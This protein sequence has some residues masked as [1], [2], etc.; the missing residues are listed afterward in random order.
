M[1]SLAIIV[2]LAIATVALG[3]QQSNSA[4]VIHMICDSGC[5]GAGGG[6]LADLQ[7]RSAANAW[8]DVGF[9]A[10]NL[11]LPAILQT[12]GNVIGSIS[13]SGF[14]VNNFPATQ[15][16]SS[17]QLPAALDG[18]GFLKTHEQGTAAT[19]TADGSDVTQ[20]SKADARSTS[21]DATPI[22]LMQVLKEISFMEQT[23]AARSVTQGTSPWVDSITLW[24][25]GTLGAMAAFGT[26]P[27]AVL[28]PGVN[29]FVT[30]FPTAFQV[31][32]FPATQAVTQSTSPWVISCSTVNCPQ[33]TLTKGTQ[34]STG[35]STQ[36]LKDSGRSAR[37][38]TLDSF[39][40]A[41]TT[42]T[43]MTMSY[44]TDNATLTTGTSYT[45]TAA[46][47][48]RIQSIT[49]NIHTIAGNTTAVATIVRLRVNNGG[50]AVVTS[51]VQAILAIQGVAAASQAGIPVQV[52]FPDGWEFVAGAGIGVTVGCGGFV[53]TTAAPKVDI[54]LV[55]FEY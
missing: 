12:G 7:V 42:E 48:L 1:R 9:F 20:G 31:S 47:R 44:S 4:N 11:F 26:S 34:G 29:A 50:A 16:I 15:A 24:A 45:V 30:N 23:P 36:D 18:S 54:T 35:F 10:G 43:L 41:A 13:N 3:Q 22:T 53:A 6:G 52:N 17:L 38:I 49:A 27:G 33:P 39:A 51:P 14:N 2:L 25:G 40:I 46:K 55:G 21:T 37:T 5:V 32:N 19:S 8:T 28:V